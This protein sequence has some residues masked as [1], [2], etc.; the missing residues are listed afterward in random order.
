[1][2][3]RLQ[4]LLSCFASVL[5]LSPP[6]QAITNTATQVPTECARKPLTLS[7]T[8][9]WYPY[10]F[11]S[12]SG[13]TQGIDVEILRN[14][15]ATMGCTLDIEHFP[16]RRSLFQLTW[17]HFDIG[18]GASFT[19]DRAKDFHYTHAYRDEVNRFVYKL[20]DSSIA[21]VTSLEQLVQK[22]KIIAINLAGWYGEE[23]EQAKQE[24]NGFVFSDTAPK[25]LQ[26]LRLNRVDIV[27]DDEVVLCSELER[28]QLT[29]LSLHPLV[30]SSAPIH[31]IFNKKTV[32]QRFITQFNQILDT[33]QDSGE[34]DSIINQFASA[35]CLSVS[36]SIGY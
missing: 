34:L 36:Q 3:N 27:I 16:E 10:I 30:L 7:I 22:K 18:L 2:H 33:M 19:E 12:H 31:F 14:V 26:M 1:M 28:Q 15:L 11:Q 17:G 23:L 32:S 24:Y 35:S 4:L 29:G 21:P 5:F 13:K 20:N 25:R 9:D 6:S 8:S